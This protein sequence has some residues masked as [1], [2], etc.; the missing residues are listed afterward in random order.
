MIG[1]VPAAGSAY[2]ISPLPCSKEILPVGFNQQKAHPR[3]KVVGHYLLENMRLA[4]VRKAC[5][6]LRREKW[7]IASYFG[8][9]RIVDMKLAYILTPMNHGVPFTL[10]A[11]YEFIK[12]HIIVFGFPDI[13]FKPQT[14]FTDLLA[15]LNQK[16]ADLVLGLFSAHEPSKMDMVAL[17]EARKISHIDIKPLRSTLSYTWIIAVW[18]PVFTRFMKQFVADHKADN[19]SDAISTSAKELFLG[20]VIDAAIHEKVKIEKVIFQNG[21]YLDIGTPGDFSKVTS[22]T[23]ENLIS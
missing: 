9:G 21:D 17:D 3:L 13:V 14:A 16:Q 12:D 4:G 15:H 2:R 10:D 23:Q 11:A 19:T 18:T 22:F 7:D 8:D 20:D 1:L 5:I 6:V